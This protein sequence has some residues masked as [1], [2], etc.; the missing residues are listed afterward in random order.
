MRGALLAV[1]LAA[2]AGAAPAST[3]TKDGV[4]L[5]MDYSPAR[6]GKTT[7]VLLHGLGASRREWDGFVSSLAARG[8]GALAVD[9]RGHGRSGGPSF[10]HFRSP[11]A[12]A[13]LA[14]DLAAALRWLAKKGVPPSR[15][16]LAGSS[17]GANAALIAAGREPRLPFL[18]LLSPGANYQGLRVADHL[19]GYRGPVLLGASKEDAY[20]W[21]TVEAMKKEMGPRARL[22]EAPSGHGSP[23]L[24]DADFAT[25]VFGEIERLTSSGPRPSAS[26][27]R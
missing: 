11:E 19:E 5:A 24:A 13:G 22:L 9:A 6:G 17:I 16:A 4:V 8:Y 20:A 25:R 21:R 14:E 23:M 27:A 26:G 10:R 12:W 1:L 2:P 7:F 15:A 18:L 3:K